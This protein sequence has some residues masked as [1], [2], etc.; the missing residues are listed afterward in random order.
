M[1]KFYCFI[2]YTTATSLFVIVA[3]ANLLCLMEE[4]PPDKRHSFT[5]SNTTLNNAQAM[6]YCL[7]LFRQST[8]QILSRPE[9]QAWRNRWKQVGKQNNLSIINILIYKSESIWE[10]DLWL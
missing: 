3:K 8:V 10:R 7:S 2:F 4:Q 1:G 5:K 6:L 9:S